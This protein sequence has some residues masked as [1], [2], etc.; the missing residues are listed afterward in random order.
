MN[1]LAH[2]AGRDVQLRGCASHAA[3][4]AHGVEHPQCA[5]SMSKV[6]HVRMVSKDE[7]WYQQNSNDVVRS[8]TRYS[9][10]ALRGFAV[11]VKPIRAPSRQGGTIVADLGFHTS[12]GTY[13]R[14]RSK[15]MR[16]ALSLCATMTLTVAP[17]FAQDNYPSRSITIIA[18][19]APGSA[20]DVFTRQVATELS[21]ALGQPVVV[22][23][24][25]GA[26]GNIGTAAIVRSPPDGYTI[27]QAGQG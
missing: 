7:R 18:P 9:A 21:N 1:L 8:S 24:K 26:G 14:V 20:A 15:V 12:V 2:G 19:L 16:V 11:A 23:N 3:R 6:A 25:V 4:L 5:E 17:V 13:R 22:E 27:G 10:L